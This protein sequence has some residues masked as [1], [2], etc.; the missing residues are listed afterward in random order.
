MGPRFPVKRIL[1][2]VV[3]ALVYLL[4]GMIALTVFFGSAETAFTVMVALTVVVLCM[5]FN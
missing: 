2:V 4:V 1:I 5:M 3:V